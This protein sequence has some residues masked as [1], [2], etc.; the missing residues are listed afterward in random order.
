MGLNLRTETAFTDDS[1]SAQLPLPP[2][3]IAPHFPQLEILECLGRGGMGVVYQARQKS[4]NR[5]VALKLLAPERVG[6]AKFA[7]RF[8][9]EAQALAALNHPN[10]VTIH[11]FGQAGGFYFL[12]MEFVD[13]L[14]LRQ[15][16][17]GRKFTPEEALAIVPPLC[18]AL[19]FAHDRG[20]VHRDIKPEN[21]LLDKAGRIK[22]ADF[23]IAKMLGA[24]DRAGRPLPADAPNAAD[25]AHGVTRPATKPSALTGGQA[26]GTPSYSAPEQKTD[27]QRVDSRADIYSLGVVFYELLTGELPGMPLQAPSKKVQ[28]DVRLD[29]VVLRALEQ[30]PELRYQQASVLKTQVE[31]IASTPGGQAATATASNLTPRGGSAKSQF[32]RVVEILLGDP[33]ESPLAR[34]LVNLSALGFLAGLGFLSSVPG[35]ERCLGFS[36]FTG[37]FGLIGVAYIVE[38]VARRRAKPPAGGSPARPPRY[39]AL[40]R[41]LFLAGTLGSLSLIAVWY[42]H[43]I[44]LIFD[45]KLLPLLHP[46][47]EPSIRYRVFEI[48]P[49]VADQLVPN[50]EREQGATGNWQMA[51]ISPETLASLVGRRVLNR[52]TMCDRHLVIR[53]HGSSETIVT[54][55]APGVRK[56]QQQVIAGWRVVADNWGHT[57]AN[58]VA[59][60]MAQLNLH[61][62]FAIRRKEG[63]LQLKIEQVLTHRIGD[64]PAVDVHIGY[65]GNAPRKGV[66][67]CFIPFARNNDTTGCFLFT[68]EVQEAAGNVTTSTTANQANQA[69]PRNLSF[70]PVL[71][72]VIHARG[73]GTNLFLDL[74]TGELL[75]PPKNVIEVLGDNEAYWQGWD[76][77]SESRPYQY[78]AWMK[79]SG[80]DLRV[81]GDREV[82]G[83]DG[84]FVLAHGTNSA[85]WDAWDGITPAQTIYVGNF[86]AWSRVYQKN[87]Q[88]S[89]PAPEYVE[90]VPHTLRQAEQRTSSEWGA[91][92]VSVLKPEQSI[93]YYFRTREGAVGLM[94]II[95]FTGN[96][97]AV[98]IRYKLVQSG[99][100]GGV[101]SR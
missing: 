39:A 33:L 8:T 56:P 16:L 101:R 58:Q 82:L 61:G 89:E 92:V 32:V 86:A 44:A 45:A 51:A 66:L 9:R 1:A 46:Q 35:W 77:P 83:F 97:R 3:Q 22:V 38:A 48:E 52:H 12:L 60:D 63:V 69:V 19:Q 23:G 100:L 99:G 17:R 40:G 13:G 6:D 94:Q 42:R 11:D 84:A 96:P 4:L 74:D 76:I 85:D 70:G 78:I 5:L 65:E 62:F 91:P 43:E 24:E 87:Q 30:Q 79:Q 7:E 25:G 53:N 14:N 55:S 34:K 31:T 49:A 47:A 21:L 80:A 36:G 95:G 27:P 81:H 90:G 59:N 75:T 88:T 18:D 50:A 37:F 54:S 20:I 71:E 98:K 26:I 15:L 67:A 64:R 57:L 29:E 2:D 72:R 28:I 41:G 10:I 93:T 68:V 73:A